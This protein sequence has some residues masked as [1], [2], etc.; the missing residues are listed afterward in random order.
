MGTP[1]Y[2]SPEQCTGAGGVDDKTDVYA[3]GVM[4]FR[5]LAGRMPFVAT[6]SGALMAKHIYEPPPSLT[7]FAPWLPPSIVAL[8][9]RLLVKDKDQR[10][11][12]ATLS[13]ELQQ[14]QATLA[15]FELPPQ[16]LVEDPSTPSLQDDGIQE[17][18]ELDEGASADSDSVMPTVN[19]DIAAVS[20]AAAAAGGIPHPSSES[21]GFV[22]QPSTL[23]TSTGERA[24]LVVPVAKTSR[25]QLVAVLSGAV[26]L[27]ALLAVSLQQLRGTSKPTTRPG[28]GAV[29][30][31]TPPP[32]KHVRWSLNTQPAGAEIIRVSTG[33]VLGQTP[34]QAELPTDQGTEELRLQLPGYQQQLLR[35]DRSADVQLSYALKAAPPEDNSKGTT[36]KTGPGEPGSP[37][38]PQTGE[39][40]T[41]STKAPKDPGKHRKKGGNVQIEFEE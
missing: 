37:A 16:A 1:G 34:W 30:P 39:K 5:L 8:V 20:A 14:L 7:E 10:P 12:M 18:S 6:G 15:D 27:G 26:L 41:T 22:S 3:L 13:E 9:G 31:A 4:M 29:L 24:A 17:R 25:K 21:S 32:K 28:A 35:L 2:M 19:V 40:P 11:T 33:Q 23:N 38:A 36:V